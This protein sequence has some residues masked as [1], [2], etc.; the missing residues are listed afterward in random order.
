MSK[1]LQHFL[2]TLM[3]LLCFA[4]KSYAQADVEYD[5]VYL[6]FRYLQLISTTVVGYYK[7]DTFYLPVGEIFNSLLIYN[8]FDWNVPRIH[9]YINTESQSFSLNFANL[10]YRYQNNRGELTQDD[11]YIDQFDIYLASDKFQE[12]FGMDFRIELSVMAMRLFAEERL[13]IRLRQE[14]LQARQRLMNRIGTVELHEPR[15]GRKPQV[16]NG[17]FLDYNLNLSTQRFDTYSSNLSLVGGSELLFGDF[18]GSITITNNDFGQTDIRYNN[19]RWRYYNPSGLVRQVIAGN[20]INRGI[21]INQPLLGVR[22]TNEPLF[23]TRV[24]DEFNL[25]ETAVPDSE[26]EIYI[27]DRLFDFL[28]VDESGRYDLRMPITYGINDIRVVKYGPDGQITETQQRLNVPFY[29]VPP[30]QLYY[31]AYVAQ[32]RVTNLNPNPYYVGLLDVGYGINRSNTFRA[33]GELVT[34]QEDAKNSFIAEYSNRAFSRL[35]T[36]I[37]YSPDRFETVNMSY[38]SFGNNFLNVFAS[39][40]RPSYQEL[41]NGIRYRYGAQGFVNLQNR[42]LPFYVRAG[43]DQSDFTNLTTTN[44]NASVTARVNRLA[45]I[46]G[47]RQ[48]TRSTETLN[49][50][51]M[52][53]QFSTSYSTP[54]T[55]N[56]WWPIRGIFM[57]AQLEFNENLATLDRIDFSASRSVFRG[58]QFQTNISHFPISGQT[59]FFL[60][61]SFDIPYARFN[62][63]YRRSATNYTINQ[64]VRGSVGYFP[65]DNIWLFDSR[66]QVGRSAVVF[67][68]FI[69]TD[70]D[71]VYS[72]G[73]ISM[74]YNSM[75]IL[76]A[77]ARSFQKKDRIIFTQLRQYENYNVEVNMGLV[78]DPTLVSLQD[79]FSITTDP[80][81][82]KYIEVPFSRSGILDGIVNRVDGG[83]TQAVGG[84]TVRILS[85]RDSTITSAR[86]FFDGSFYQMELVPGMYEVFPDTTQLA[87]LGL[88]STPERYAFQITSSELGDFVSINFELDTDRPFVPEPLPEPEPIEIVDHFRI[89]VALMSTLPRAIIA[90]EELEK[91][92][93]HPFELQ[94]SRRTSNFRVFSQEVAGRTR[95]EELLASIHETQFK[96]AFIIDNVK[97]ETEDIFYSVQIGAFRTERNANILAQQA[98]DRFGLE[99]DVTFDPFVRW[100]VIQTRPWSNWV[101]ADSQRYDIRMNTEYR[102]AF[103]VTRAPVDLK[104]YTFSLQIGVYNNSEH[105]EQVAEQFRESTGYRFSV[106]YNPRIKVYR[107][108]L[109]NLVNWVDAVRIREELMKMHGVEEVLILTFGSQ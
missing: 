26:V 57:R 49:I 25:S 59:S 34:G 14:R 83:R 46:G 52:R 77:G 10:A 37:Q 108:Q 96:D 13:P 107:V 86:T 72:D 65:K 55:Q 60:T 11:F 76:G 78:Q 79:K 98:R 8:E 36:N 20:I 9:G 5:E 51:Q 68:T 32:T 90:K 19:A 50:S 17:G 94:Y 88:K 85:L 7:N 28:K 45:L 82:F 15:I 58:G 84:L 44:V 93:N 100:Y 105:A 92:T 54:R 35:I 63:S 87:M 56:L 39:N 41:N 4:P 33:K 16:F 95:A 30:K 80:N 75:R 74:R 104:R 99:V 97:F 70:G 29:F 47:F 103:V 2:L 31:S 81:Q 21:T 73:D 22:V 64:N 66:Q 62:T 69:D 23:P 89:Q 67:N 101:Q 48:L 40:F 109:T 1:P 18:Q 106:N 38:Q 24:F 27:N 61:L 71:G 53:Y 91:K 43:Y 102:D 12:I 6:E 3:I 42:V